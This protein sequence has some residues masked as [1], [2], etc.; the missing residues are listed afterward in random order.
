MVSRL[1]GTVTAGDFALETSS[2]AVAAF[3]A[4]DLLADPRPRVVVCVADTAA[5][6]L[7]SRQQPDVADADACRKARIDV[8]KRR[9]GGGVVLVEPGAL[10]WFDV[11]VPADDPR[12]QSVVA[13]VGASMR[14]LGG[15]LA[16]ALHG[17]GVARAAVHDG[18]MVGGRWGDVVCFAGLGPG[19]VLVDGAK[20][21]GISQRRTRNGSRFQCMVHVRWSPNVLIPLLAEPRPGLG[22]LPPVAL[23]SREVAEALPGMV[24]RF[25]SNATA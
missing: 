18:G 23:V 24:A 7:G 16:T 12:F 17:L 11:V 2:G 13:D 21:V 5:L 4:A 15:Y 14:W 9:S 8:V 20:L 6:V 25:L 3:H 10:C 19:E 1:A 22:E